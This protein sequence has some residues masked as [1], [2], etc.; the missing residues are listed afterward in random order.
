[1]R[2]QVQSE[3]QAKAEQKSDLIIVQ[4]KYAKQYRVSVH[5]WSYGRL[6]ANIQTQAAKVGIVIEESKQPIT[7]SPQEKA[8]ELVIAAYHSRKIN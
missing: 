1:M 3:I 8:K 5:Q 4:K 7:A 6:I 2:E